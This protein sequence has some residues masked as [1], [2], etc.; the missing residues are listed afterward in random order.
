MSPVFFRKKGNGG[1]FEEK[2]GDECGLIPLFSC[3]HCM[4]TIEWFLLDKGEELL[5]SNLAM[6]I[7]LE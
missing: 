5:A 4:G 6:L 7:S 2:K 3:V 1:S